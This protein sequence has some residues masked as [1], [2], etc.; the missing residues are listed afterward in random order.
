[1]NINWKDLESFLNSKDTDINSQFYK[2]QFYNYTQGVTSLNIGGG[3]FN[4]KNWLNLDS[5]YS[6]N[7]LV[8]FN[9]TENTVFPVIS[10]SINICY[11]SHCFEHLPNNVIFSV[12]KDAHRSLV[13]D[14]FFVIQIP[15]FDQG[16]KYWQ[17]N[18]PSFV[19][20]LGV[21][22]I[23]PSWKNRN[24]DISI[25]NMC[26]T[27]FCAFWNEAYGN[28][29]SNNRNFDFPGY[30]G[31]PRVK[32][33]DF[34]VLLTSSPNYISNFLVD[35]TLSQESSIDISFNHRNSW[36]KVEFIDLFESFNFK[37]ISTD[38]SY[39]NNIF[40]Y[41]PDFNKRSSWSSFF[42]FQKS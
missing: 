16:L 38:Y 12:L 13:K 41:I 40:S 31:C 33:S 34:D 9:L 25:N 23:T 14:G 7:N 5:S 28:H 36:S 39:I 27:L 30:H 3:P 6:D 15:N 35:I 37:L 24:V 21:D 8:T 2:N 11:S 22:V 42:L 29:Y 26:S 18:D 1:M 19:K 17:N 32:A 20:A 10:N 4:L